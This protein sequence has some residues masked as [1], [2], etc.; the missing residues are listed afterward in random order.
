MPSTLP[1][2]QG[3]EKDGHQALVE[4]ARRSVRGELAAGGKLADSGAQCHCQ[5]TNVAA[6]PAASRSLSYR[7]PTP[8][9]AAAR[10]GLA[11]AVGATARV[12]HKLRRPSRT[13][14]Q[15]NPLN[16]KILGSLKPSK[17]TPQGKAH[18]RGVRVR[19]NTQCRGRLAPGTTG[20]DVLAE[21]DH[22]V[23]EQVSRHQR[24]LAVV[25]LGEGQFA[26]GIEEVCS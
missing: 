6:N 1:R 15:G 12:R 4:N 26:V 5:R 2:A 25:E 16:Q 8:E 19:R 21:R 20:S 11:R 22:P 10:E 9:L 7:H 14:T 17:L 24:G 18:I 23:V 3:A 13:R